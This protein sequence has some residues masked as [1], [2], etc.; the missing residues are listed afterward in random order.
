M[1]PFGVIFFVLLLLK[2]P[3]MNLPAFGDEMF[4]YIWPAHEI[5][6]G[7]FREMTYPHFAYNHPPGV[8]LI[9]FLFFS[10]WGTDIFVV[11]LCAF[12]FSVMTLFYTF[13]TGEMLQGNGKRTGIL[14]TLCLLLTPLF[15]ASSTL[16]F[17][18]TIVAAFTTF[19]FFLVLRGQWKTAIVTGLFMGLARETSLAFGVGALVLIL[20]EKKVSW[21]SLLAVCSPFISLS[22]FYLHH[23]AMTGNF[24]NHVAI[25]DGDI[26]FD[27][28]QSLF[29]W[30]RFSEWSWFLFYWEG[31]IVLTL[32]A[33]LGLLLGKGKWKGP[34]L[35]LGVIVLIFLLFFSFDSKALIRY[36]LPV[37]PSLYLLFF[38]WIGRSFPRKDSWLALFFLVLAVPMIYGKGFAGGG[39]LKWIH[40][41]TPEGNMNYRLVTGVMKEVAQYLEKIHPEKT[42]LAPWPMDM[43]FASPL[44]GYVDKTL[45]IKRIDPRGEFASIGNDYH[46]FLCLKNSGVDL[47]CPYRDSLRR[48]DGLVLLTSF[49][50]QP[51]SLEIYTRPNFRP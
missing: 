50:R 40:P 6:T 32:A 8:P 44:W 49:S 30:E 24:L 51:Y 47:H 46:F 20:R 22:L 19:Y 21:W 38:S 48:R 9:L 34:E 41:L 18:D 42:I 3:H 4:A 15:F 16:F 39:H 36:F 14:A 33:F 2:F 37:F 27:L 43:A 23:K 35:A 12:S 1:L 17:G 28:S 45:Q 11:R 7:G 5:L 25:S 26:S 13:K 31:R 10:V 29:I